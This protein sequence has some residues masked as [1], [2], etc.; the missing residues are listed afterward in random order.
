MAEE[1]ITNIRSIFSKVEEKDHLIIYCSDGKLFYNDKD[2]KQELRHLEFMLKIIN[3][4]FI[5]QFCTRIKE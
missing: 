2:K 3:N 4:W 1:K 5:W